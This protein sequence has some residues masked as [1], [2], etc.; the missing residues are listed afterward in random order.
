MVVYN[1]AAEY[2]AP[3][4]ILIIILSFRTDYEEKNLVNYCMK[5]L[6]GITFLASIA[7]TISIHVGI[8]KD[9]YA[10]VTLI[11]IT[12]TLYLITT[13]L[14]SGLYLLLCTMVAERENNMVALRK[15]LFL[16]VTPYMVYATIVLVNIGNGL[17]SSASSTE[18]YIRGTWF[19]LPFLIVGIHILLIARIVVVNRRYIHREVLLVVV[20]NM[21]LAGSLSVIQFMYSHI[22][23]T[24]V[25][26]IASILAMHLYIQSERNYISQLTGSK[27][28]IALHKQ[29]DTYSEKGISFSLYVISLRDFKSINERNGIEFGNKTLK[30]IT[31][32]IMGFFSYDY[33]YRYSGDEFAIL[34]REEEDKEA[35]VK[36][37]LAHL[38]EPM[39]VENVDRIFL[40]FVCAKVDS[41]HFGSTNKELIAS[42]EYS[43]SV[44]KQTRGETQYLY[45]PHIMKDMTAR[46]DKIEQIRDA[47]E[48]RKLQICYQPIY[49][50]NNRD[51]TQAEA[52]VR[53]VET[54]GSLLLPEEFIDL[55]EA[56]GLVVPMT[57]VV[58][59][60]VCEDFRKLIDQ[61]GD[62]LVLETISVNLPYHIFI[63]SNMQG[64]IENILER[65][66][67]APSLIKIEITERTLISDYDF[68]IETME[69][70]KSKGFVF[71][72][73][74]FGVDYSNMSTLLTL[75]M[76]VIK[77]D[78]NVIIAAL[79]STN[80][81]Q[82][83]KHLV[84]GI[85]ETGRTVIVEGVE[86]REQLDFIIECGCEYI[87]GFIFSRPLQ[88]ES[89]AQFI[90]PETQQKF[91]QEFLC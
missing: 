19:Q 77:I 22:I 20:I 69:Q 42:V 2:A 67:I 76:E 52:L 9:G 48:N 31:N 21:T 18:G 34:L 80:N 39:N 17:I 91:I 4:I 82:F 79:K 60:M 15:N 56:T 14:P 75:P 84:D 87:Q 47:V 44:L 32:E 53:I 55:A 8:P 12:N 36:E 5:G 37:C 59:E 73:D 29:M 13:P 23:M 11:L 10:N 45:D 25:G 43:L 6:Y 50:K 66:E 30:A 33:I 90:I 61:Y 83:F 3:F 89:F 74:D 64:K 28:R 88:L 38:Q 85:K 58:L 51:F 16:C 86:D 7:L 71:E 65:Y 78:H 63:S 57:Y 40:D 41:Q 27:N 72:L 49:S 46:R 70:M 68:M 62:D 54:D 35:L 81:K 1:L 24:S 26:N